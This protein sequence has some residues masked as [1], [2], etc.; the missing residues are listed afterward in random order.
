MK[1]F[2]NKIVL[3]LA[4]LFTNLD[5]WI[6]EHVQPSIDMA[7]K[8]KAILNNPLMD[9]V[10]A[11]IPGDLDNQARSFA[12]DYLTQAINVLNITKDISKEA[13]WAAK[14]TKMLDY[15]RTLSPSLQKGFFMRLVSEMAKISAGSESDKVK[16]HS[17]DL[18]VQM[19]Y[20]KLKE[21][22]KAE[23]LP[24]ETIVN[25]ELQPTTNQ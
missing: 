21:G 1:K 15:I 4:T 18:L 19:Q 11:L 23:D 6:H 14:V 25:G 22:L 20:S 7:E 2:F 24:S 16:G 17:I 13:D 10:V 3:F 9:I 12:I 8:L 5:N